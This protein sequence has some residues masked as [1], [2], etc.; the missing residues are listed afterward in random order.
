MALVD[1]GDLVIRAIN[2]TVIN[3]ES[4]L[5]NN[6]VI[7]NSVFTKRTPRFSQNAASFTQK[8]ASPWPW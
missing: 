2:R 3:L 1:G 5:L 8:E 7:R 4:Q 6:Y